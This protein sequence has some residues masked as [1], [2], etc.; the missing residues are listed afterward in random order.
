MGWVWQAPLLIYSYVQACKGAAL[1]AGVSVGSET[2]KPQTSAAGRKR[3]G[4]FQCGQDCGEGTEGGWAEGPPEASQWGK[5][6][7][8][9]PPTECVGHR[10]SGRRKGGGHGQE[11]Q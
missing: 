9:E 8:E 2:A 4:D 10:E 3:K 5:A 11:G 7:L 1:R 6:G